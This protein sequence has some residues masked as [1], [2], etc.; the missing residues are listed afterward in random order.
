MKAGL[1]LL[2][3]LLSAFMSCSDK[4]KT[5]VKETKLEFKTLFVD[6]LMIGKATEML[7]VDSNL[8]IS[9]RQSDSLF[10]W[11]N[12]N[13]LT[14]K[15][16]GQIGQGPGEFLHFDNFYHINNNYGFYD[17]RLRTSNDIIFLKDRILL[18]KN[19]RY[20]S[21]HYRLVPTAFNTFVG[22]G[23]YEKG[24]FHILD[25]KGIAVDTI[26][27]QPYRDEA[28]R[29]VPELARAMAYQGK[30]VTSPKGDYLVHAIF[31]SPII[32]FYKLS[33]ANIELLKS[34]VDCYPTYKP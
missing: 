3:A 13:K 22:I 4:V 31:M 11:V 28:E 10:H 2:L 21:I 7:L 25:I 8:L 5:E 6:S 1:L 19:V 15:D 33:L 23:P 17:R 20:G 30:I 27:E 18:N 9:D 14:S 29:S 24:L 32:S 12:L 34:H 26:G 16:V